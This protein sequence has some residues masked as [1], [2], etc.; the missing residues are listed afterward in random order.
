M[1]QTASPSTGAQPTAPSWSAKV[2]DYPA[3]TT[4]R[5]VLLV[6]VV[7]T[8]GIFVGEWLYLGAVSGSRAAAAPAGWLV[9]PP[10]LALAALVLLIAVAPATRER[11]RHL[12]RVPADPG[13][14]ALDR[15]QWLSARAGLKAAPR[16][17]WNEQDQGSGAQAYGLP[18]NYRIAIT[19]ALVGG[20]SRKPK[21]FDAIMRHELVHLANRD[22][23]PT[24]AARVA[25][26]VVIAM[27]AVPVAWR[28]VENDLSLLPD[29]LWRALVLVILVRAV[30]AAVL[31]CREHYA[32]IRAAS[33]SDEPLQIAEVLAKAP[34]GTRRVRAVVP[35]GWF[36]LHPPP[37]RRAGFVCDPQLL[38]RPG[39]GELFTL[40]LLPAAAQ[41]LLANLF[42]ALGQASVTADRASHTVVY[43]A[44]GAGLA[45]VA[46]RSVGTRTLGR[47][48]LLRSI[49][50]LAAGAAAGSTLSLASTGLLF[51]S[52]FLTQELFSYVQVE[53]LTCAVAGG[54]VLVML[55]DW[56][57][58]AR[59][60]REPPT[61]PTILVGMLGSG[62]VATA[63]FPAALTLVKLGPASMREGL[64]FLT[65][66]DA[67]TIALSLAAVCGTTF[68]LLKARRRSGTGIALWAGAAAGAAATTASVILRHTVT[69]FADDDAVWNYYF[70]AVWIA[71][72]AA[73]VA[74]AA[75]TAV[76]RERSI[77]GVLAGCV[78]GLAATLGYAVTDV[79]GTSADLETVYIA[80]RNI[81]LP[82]TLISVPMAGL[83][84]VLS[85]AV[86]PSR[87]R[88]LSS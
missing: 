70:D 45:A 77:A 10:L 62:L 53:A 6:G 40:G 3:S 39:T 17:M 16:L 52:A 44:L 28:L 67:A 12:V 76:R 51:S 64:P 32:D 56:L 20:A 13:Q 30:R 49:V 34:P 21:A 66:Y 82:A 35:A 14:D 42:A 18:W 59:R 71:I 69:P 24:A 43:A 84:S 4:V 65:Q 19:P 26:Q 36:S 25:G 23:L 54:A 80:M 48:P 87:K 83:A 29:F 8:A 50:V 88:G 58:L 55:A 33:W 81:G 75:V 79:L 61:A 9:T 68:A 22:V 86:T 57:R 60:G 1:T 2:L 7:L 78:A 5:A 85:R 63:A 11:R 41:P 38:G 46:A 74:S 27:L 37:A 15:L 72:I 31:R 47:W 73:A